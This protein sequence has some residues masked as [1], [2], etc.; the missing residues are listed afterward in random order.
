MDKK[1][2]QNCIHYIQHY[3]LQEGKLIRIFCGHCTCNKRLKTK[4]PDAAA[5]EHH[6][7]TSPDEEAFADK[8][9]LTK[10]LLQYMLDMELLPPIEECAKS[11]NNSGAR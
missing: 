1:T 6:A 3:V 7:P 10:K 9:Y 11:A 5:C 4:R 2:C 8:K